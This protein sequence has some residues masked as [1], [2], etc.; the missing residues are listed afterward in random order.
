MTGAARSN[1]NWAVAVFK[2]WSEQHNNHAENKCPGD[3]LKD[4][5]ENLTH[6]V[7]VSEIRE[8]NNDFYR[9]RSIT[10][11]LEWGGGLQR[12]LNESC[13]P[14]NHVRICDPTNPQIKQ[15]YVVL[16][17][18]FHELHSKVSEQ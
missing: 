8:D 2:Q 13:L 10:Q 16:D 18:L 14:D 3:I 11:L 12:F 6:C 15:V 1:I 7:F 5:S 4:E 9:P 17:R